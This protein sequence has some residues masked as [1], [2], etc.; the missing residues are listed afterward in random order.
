MSK[1]DKYLDGVFVSLLEEGGV[2][3]WEWYEDSMEEVSDRNDDSEVAAAL[4]NGG[5][6]NWTWYDESLGEFF[7]YQDYVEDNPNDYVGYDEWLEKEDARVEQEEAEAEAKAAQEAQEEK[8]T[9]LSQEKEM[10]LGYISQSFDEEKAY[11][12]FERVDAQFWKRINN[13][14][15]FEKAM[16]LAQNDKD[17]FLEAARN[18]F[19]N[20]MKK[21]GKLDKMIEENS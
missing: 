6:D 12:V 4:R 10:L 3:N 13:P 1:I 21:N 2:D 20:I 5:V 8:P 9:A 14:K 18:H 17:N 15:E 16:E 7:S 11:E 19:F